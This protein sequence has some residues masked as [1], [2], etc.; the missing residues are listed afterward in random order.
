MNELFMRA[1]GRRAFIHDRFLVVHILK[2]KLIFSVSAVIF[3]RDVSGDGYDYDGDDGTDEIEEH[4]N[5]KEQEETE[6]KL[7]MHAR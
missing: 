3:R 1:E 7:Q 4:K 2:L 6:Q 5:G